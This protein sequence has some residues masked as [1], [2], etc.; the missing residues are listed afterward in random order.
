[1]DN[2]DRDKTVVVEKE[3]PERSTSPLGVILGIIV[4]LV[5][6]VLAFNLF[7]G[8]NGTENTGTGTNTETTVPAP[9]DTTPAPGDTTP[10]PT[11]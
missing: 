10:A 5:L 7:V 11:E 2:N 8:D 1:M 3:T 6:A 4:L 9:N